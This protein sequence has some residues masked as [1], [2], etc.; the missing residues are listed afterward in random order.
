[1]T[2]SFT[3]KI[4]KKIYR[5]SKIVARINAKTAKIK[6]KSE[7]SAAK[8]AAKRTRR[9]DALESHNPIRRKLAEMKET[10]AKKHEVKMRKLESDAKLAE[11]DPKL[12]ADKARAENRIKIESARMKTKTASATAYATGAAAL[13]RGLSDENNQDDQANRQSEL[14]KIQTIFGS[15]TTNPADSETGLRQGV[16]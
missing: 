13:G 10:G 8:A 4:N 15:S 2:K 16:E 3:Q 5:D 14:D 1:M 11:L 6:A 7:L 12:A 9:S